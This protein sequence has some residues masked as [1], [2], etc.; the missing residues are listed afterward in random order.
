ML[1]IGLVTSASAAARYFLG[2]APGCQ[3]GYYLRPDDHVGRWIGGGAIALGLS[4]GIDARGED[5]F[6]LLLDGRAPRGDRL[7]EPVM[8]SDPRSLLP[9]SPLVKAVR[10]A[11][12]AMGV[13][14][15]YL[16]DDRR[17]ADQFAALARRAAGRGVRVDVAERIAGRTGRDLHAIYGRPGRNSS[18]LVERARRYLGKQVDTRRAAYDLTFSAPKSVSLLAAFGDPAVAAHVHAS[19]TA[20]V[21]AALGWLERATATAARGH[22]GDGQRAARVAT[23]GFVAAAFDHGTSRAGDPQVHT[24][25][26][27]A[28]LLQGVDG[29]WS[30]V[31][32]RALYRQ[33]KT[34]GYLYQAAL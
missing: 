2:D 30:A 33:S 23:S 24:H 13:P 28:N 1:S 20:A 26:V 31:D 12:A 25:V 4:G 32:S 19:H 14:V 5:A 15:P 3:A 6:R 22:H 7:V 16:L 11:A 18:R 34:A 21:A 8:R 27:V 29:R 17:L 10:S 9:A